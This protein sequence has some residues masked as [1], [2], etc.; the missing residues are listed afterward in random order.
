[1]ILQSGD[2]LESNNGNNLEESYNLL[3]NNT[4]SLNFFVA[5]SQIIQEV[6]LIHNNLIVLQD[7][8]DKIISKNS[9][10]IHT[11]N[12]KD[13]VKCYLFDL[14]DLLYKLNKFSHTLADILVLVAVAKH[15]REMDNIKYNIEA[16][17]NKIKFLLKNKPLLF[18]DAFDLDRAQ[19]LFIENIQLT[20]NYSLTHNNSNL[21]NSDLTSK[22]CLN[23]DFI[24]QTSLIYTKEIF[25]YLNNEISQLP[26][27]VKMGN[28]D[29][30]NSCINTINTITNK[31]NT[32]N[33]SIIKFVTRLSEIYRDCLNIE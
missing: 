23:V 21:T 28:T 22:T 24:K 12:L 20:K 6:N 27:F 7:M 32:I 25:N 13:S 1:M 15:G 30:D 8:I 18:L 31:L 9:L 4:A 5:K 3:K 17:D 19:Y 11:V 33:L 16:I 10:V 14:D 29:S 2:N 26:A